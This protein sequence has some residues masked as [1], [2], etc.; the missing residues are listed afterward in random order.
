[1]ASPRGYFSLLPAEA[2]TISL[3]ASMTG[4]EREME[5][6]VGLTTADRGEASGYGQM[7]DVLR[8]CERG[9]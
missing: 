7:I 4:R 5:E 3:E 1:M 2:T 9:S 6:E 8:E